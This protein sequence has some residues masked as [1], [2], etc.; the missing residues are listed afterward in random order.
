MPEKQ[1][2]AAW[3]KETYSLELYKRYAIKLINSSLY[4][5]YFEKYALQKLKAYF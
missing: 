4:K 5:W 1:W 3:F 2:K